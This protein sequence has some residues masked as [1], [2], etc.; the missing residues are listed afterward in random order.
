[1]DG[2]LHWLIVHVGHSENIMAINEYFVGHCTIVL[3]RLHRHIAR[4]NPS[5]EFNEIFCL[6]PKVTS[7][8]VAD[9]ISLIDDLLQVQ[10]QPAVKLMVQRCMP[11]QW[12]SFQGTRNIRD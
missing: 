2:C 6:V 10:L 3:N 7:C 1:M 11:S 8:H 5:H 12:E 4:S 9:C